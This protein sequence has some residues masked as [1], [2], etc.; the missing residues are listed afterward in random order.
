MPS[1]LRETF[2][3]LALGAAGLAMALALAGCGQEAACDTDIVKGMA[4][5]AVR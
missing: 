3:R 5:E 1:S 4:I 2:R